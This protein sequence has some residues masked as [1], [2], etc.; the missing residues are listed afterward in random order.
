MSEFYFSLGSIILDD[1]VLPDGVTR[2]AVLGGGSTHAAMGMRAWADQVGI[3]AAIGEDFPPTSLAELGAY[4]DLQGLQRR[5]GQTARAWQVYEADGQRTEVFRSSLAAFLAN[6]PRPEECPPAYLGSA[7]VHLQCAMPEPLQAWITHLRAG[8]C[9]LLLWEPWD[10]DCIPEKRP[11]FQALLPQVEVFSPNLGEARQLTGLSDPL[12]VAQALLADGVPC[13]ALR[14]GGQGSLV[15]TSNGDVHSIP[16][17]PPRE[18]VDVTGAGN[19]YCGGFLVGLARTGDL[20]QAA[21]YGAVS[22][23]LA[24]EQYGA[25]IPLEDLHERAVARLPRQADLAAFQ[26][27]Q[28]NPRRQ[29]FDRMA[30]TWDLRPAPPDPP[31]LLRRVAAAGAFPPGGKILD[32]GA[33]TG[34][35]TPYLLEGQPGLVVALDLSTAMLRIL[36]ERFGAQ[37][38]VQPTA[39]DG[40]WLPFPSAAFDSLFCHAVFPH[41]ADRVAALAELRRVLKKGGRLV[42]SHATGRQVVNAIHQNAPDEILH[43]DLLPPAAELAELLAANGW[44]VV[45][46]VDEAEIYLVVAVS[47]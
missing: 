24:L 43:G 11:I 13:V 4:F 14:M 7:G 28:A 35:L 10:I 18:L 36:G 27:A 46:S 30:P 40:S 38:T 44:Q 15:V 5:P 2:M 3:V 47:L 25:L 42:I 6:T 33:G 12:Q 22:A 29:V 20:A 9:R 26:T 19:A 17:V 34:V 39:A 32:L 8:G 21:R 31:P 23:S 1:I 16:V 45:E 41:F 37:T